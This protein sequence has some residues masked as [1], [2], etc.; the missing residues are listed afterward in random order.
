M[1]TAKPIL[2][3]LVKFP[4]LLQYKKMGITPLVIKT[5]NWSF[6]IRCKITIFF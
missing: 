1:E 3:Y 2:A 5:E 4:T 6:P